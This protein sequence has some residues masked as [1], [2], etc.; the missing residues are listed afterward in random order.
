MKKS[1]I[2]T[3]KLDLEKKK[4]Q[5]CVVIFL[6]FSYLLLGLTCFC[7]YLFFPQSIIRTAV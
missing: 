6:S 7:R 2:T 3:A 4:K 5:F 1:S